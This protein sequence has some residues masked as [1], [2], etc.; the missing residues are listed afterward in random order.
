MQAARKTELIDV[1][2]IK[3][4]S[5]RRPLSEAAIAGM[6]ASV[7][8]VGMRTPI[9]VRMLD[10]EATSEP[11]L[12]T[13]AHRLEAA[14][15]LGWERIECFVVD[16]ESD[17][18]A[19]LWEIDENLIRHALSP[20]QE[21]AAIS[22]RKAIYEELHPETKAG[23]AGANARWNATDNLSAAF[24]TATAEATGKDER[25]VRRAAARGAAL[26]SDLDAITGTSLD[27]GVELDALVNMA[28]EDRAPLI[29]RAQAGD[30]VSARTRDIS[31]LEQKAELK[32]A[33]ERNKTAIR[34]VEMTAGARFAEFIM[35]RLDVQEIDMAIDL[36]R[37][38][39]VH[40]IIAALQREAA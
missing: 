31:Y 10:E 13:G 2:A 29:E 4:R 6:I 22:E 15:R 12:V 20:A 28:K 30:K 3:V 39:K 38:S 21:A 1:D 18:L 11:E 24:A 37:G 26:G 33:E 27:K 17:A 9:T 16:H 36:L 25:T 8:E 35:A 5:D 19:R 34:V 14:K 32:E 7:R 40:D 23:A